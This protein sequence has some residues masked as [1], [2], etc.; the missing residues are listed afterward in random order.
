MKKK[1]LLLLIL[2]VPV[3]CWSQTTTQFHSTL[4]KANFDT[5]TWSFLPAMKKAAKA[6]DQCSKVQCAPKVL[7][8][9]KKATTKEKITLVSDKGA[10]VQKKMA[11]FEKE[12]LKKNKHRELLLTQ[13]FQKHPG[14]SFAN[15]SSRMR[16][17]I[18]SMESIEDDE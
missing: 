2:I 10:L 4:A 11:L 9:D 7:A 6:L 5:A 14:Y 8:I 17:Y 12:L 18:R 1:H 15:M 3:L 16:F 13:S